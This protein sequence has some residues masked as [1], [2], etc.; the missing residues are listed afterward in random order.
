MIVGF[1]TSEL[2]HELGNYAGGLGN[3][4]IEMINYL[5]KD[6]SI[7]LHVFTLSKKNEY[8]PSSSKEKNITYHWFP[9]NMFGTLNNNNYNSYMK[10]FCDAVN[11]YIIEKFLSSDPNYF[12]ILHYHDWMV[13]PILLTLH[14]LKF[15]KVKR[16]LHLHSTEYARIGNK[17]LYQD[18][19]SLYKHNLEMQGCHAA[20]LVIPVSEGFGEEIIQLYNVPK[21]KVRFVNNG[22]NFTEW[23]SNRTDH[24]SIRATI[25]INEDDPVIVFCGRLVWQKNPKI[26]L[27]SFINILPVYPRARLI[28]LGDGH[29]KTEMENITKKLKIYGNSVHFLG[30]VHGKAKMDWYSTAQLVA[31]PS[32]NEPFGLIILEAYISGTPVIIPNNIAP[33]KFLHNNISYMFSFNNDDEYRSIDELQKQILFAF[34]NKDVT[35]RMGMEGKEYVLRNFSSD[36]MG[37]NI[38]RCYK[39]ILN[40]NNLYKEL[41]E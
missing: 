36:I 27:D 29:M 26:L 19:E 8:S 24:K 34:K 37:E 18:S 40:K 28:F 13:I 15:P 35:K 11:Y 31:V 32:R 16:I 22:I 14:T 38:K 20:D 12:D 9:M 33:A 17:I 5:S 7:H 3:I 1:F 21:D 23:L 39:D 25:G 4:A 2:S 10:S 6:N 41:F 30:N